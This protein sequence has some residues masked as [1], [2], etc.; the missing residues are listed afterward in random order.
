MKQRCEQ[1]VVLPPAETQGRRRDE[2]GIPSGDLGAPAAVDQRTHDRAGDAEVE[3][4]G[5]RREE[6][7]A[8]G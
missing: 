8:C 7:C 3:E 5:Y 4:V 1:D 6:G 2:V